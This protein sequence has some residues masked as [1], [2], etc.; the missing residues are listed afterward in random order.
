M[1]DSVNN[2]YHYTQGDIECID[3]MCSMCTAEEFQGYL[4]LAAVKYLWRWRDKGG[5]EDLRKAR[6]Y[7]DHL[8]GHVVIGDQ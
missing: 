2:P 6:W 4:R 7:I 3:A 1:S 5:V 8:I